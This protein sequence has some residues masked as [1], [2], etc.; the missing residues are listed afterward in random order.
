MRVARRPTRA[1]TVAHPAGDLHRRRQHVSY[2]QAASSGQAELPTSHCA[3]PLPICLLCLQISQAAQQWNGSSQ[4]QMWA[5][6]LC[7]GGVGCEAERLNKRTTGVGLV[8]LGQHRQADPSRQCRA[9]SGQDEGAVGVGQRALEAGVLAE[10]PLGQHL[11]HPSHQRPAA[12][13]AGQ[14]VTKASRASSSAC[15]LPA[16]RRRQPA[17]APHPPVRQ[18]GARAGLLVCAYHRGG[19]V[20]QRAVPAWQRSGTGRQHGTARCCAGHR[21]QLLPCSQ[22]AQHSA[23]HARRLTL[24]RGCRWGTRRRRSRG[25]GTQ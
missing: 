12:Q 19:G 24:G 25:S 7:A 6:G 2:W 16:S 3:V 15:R 22:Q 11:T 14:R 10:P 21:R 20:S 4:Q 1:A 9:R 23:Q 8:V 13:Q 18:R 5:P 17:C